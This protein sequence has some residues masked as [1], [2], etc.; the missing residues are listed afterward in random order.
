MQAKT[1]IVGVF[2]IERGVQGSR[3]HLQGTPASP[4]RAPH[5]GGAAVALLPSHPEHKQRVKGHSSVQGDFYCETTPPLTCLAKCPLRAVL[6]ADLT[7]TGKK[8]S[9]NPSKPR[10]GLFPASP[11][12]CCVSIA[13]TVTATAL[14]PL[15]QVTQSLPSRY[16][17]EKLRCQPCHVFSKN[18]PQQWCCGSTRRRALQRRWEN[19]LPIMMTIHVFH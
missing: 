14:L 15:Q 6:Q 16:L 19:P 10:T 2:L 13:S 12:R 5:R 9:S 18:R 11:A 4:R 8:S 7:R 3:A 1:Y 17:L